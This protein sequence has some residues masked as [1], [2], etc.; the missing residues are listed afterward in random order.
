MKKR[1]KSA[2]KG[3]RGR[4]SWRVNLVPIIAGA[5]LVLGAVAALYFGGAFPK[6]WALLPHHEPTEQTDPDPIR[7]P[8]EGENQPNPAPDP[9]PDP[10]PEQDSP[11]T[12]YATIE[13]GGEAQEYDTLY[14]VGNTGFEYF[15]YL[16]ELGEKYGKGK[17]VPPCVIVAV[18]ASTI[19][20]QWNIGTCTI[21]LSAVERSILSPMDLPLLTM[22]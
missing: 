18:M 1:Y 21:I 22:L 20:K 3:Y 7:T 14:R 4:S 17:S 15:T 8:E 10:D 2:Y 16:P 13:I 12:G 6:L 19:P 11:E 5:I 9:K